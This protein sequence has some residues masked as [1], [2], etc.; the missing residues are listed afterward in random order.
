MNRADE[1]IVCCIDGY[2][3]TCM[4]LNCVME[5]I[6]MKYYILR[7]FVESK[8]FSVSKKFKTREEAVDYAFKKLPAFSEIQEEYNR[9]NHL[10]EYKCAEK[11]RFFISRH[12]A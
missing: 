2:L 9:G 5:V 4:S 6:T 3:S 8:Y 10:I 7:G 11:V 1:F 12:T